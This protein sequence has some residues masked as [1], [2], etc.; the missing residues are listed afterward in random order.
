MDRSTEVMRT[1]LDKAEELLKSKKTGPM[2]VCEIIKTILPL[3]KSGVMEGGNRS[4]LNSIQDTIG[5]LAQVN[6]TIED[7]VGEDVTPK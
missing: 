1:A 3:T 2:A 5:K 7:V 6:R 4:Q